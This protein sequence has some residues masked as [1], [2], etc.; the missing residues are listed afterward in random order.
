M[1]FRRNETARDLDNPALY[2]G[3]NDATRWQERRPERH[4]QWAIA[5]DLAHQLG[6]WHRYT[7][8]WRGVWRIAAWEHAAMAG[9]AVCKRAA[10]DGAAWLAAWQ[11][12]AVRR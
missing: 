4:Q 8:A 3:H 7:L 10:L 5:G 9:L 11:A 12:L 6:R 1:P 2:A